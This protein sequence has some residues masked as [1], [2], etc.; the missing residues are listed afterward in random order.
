MSHP[1]LGL[2]P[3]DLT[4]GHPDAAAVLRAA[5][6]R[7]AGRALEVALDADPGFRGRYGEL[8]L[9]Q[10]LADTEA[11]ADRLAVALGSGEP[12]V[13][14]AWAEQLAPR[15]RKRNVPMD[16]IIGIAQGL[17]AAAASAV[18]PDAVPALDAAIDAA[19][20]A[21]RWHRRLGGDARKRNPV[22]AFIYKGA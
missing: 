1:S 10:L 11:M 22:I 3:R 15:Y 7:L 8:A 9:R 6:S 16:D 19:V 17:R 14:G 5:R 13:M 18:A 12:G 20:A 2:P 21:L 4:A